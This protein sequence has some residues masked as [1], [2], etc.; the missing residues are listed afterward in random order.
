MK[1]SVL[2]IKV[3]KREK[4]QGARDGPC[5]KPGQNNGSVEIYRETGH[6]AQNWDCPG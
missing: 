1:R 5:I 6:K 2:L 4:K 3:K